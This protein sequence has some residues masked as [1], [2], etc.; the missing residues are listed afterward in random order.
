MK[1]RLLSLAFAAIGA[2]TFAGGPAWAQDWPKQPIK[3]IVGYSAGGTTDL[4]AR[5]LAEP[6]GEELGAT[7]VVDNRPGAGGAIGASA[8]AKAAP[9]GYTLLFAASPEIAIAPAVDQQLNYDPRKD[10]QPIA[11]VCEIP[12]VL[13]VNAQLP[14]NSVAELRKLAQSKPGELNFASFGNGTSNHLVGELF[15]AE[16]GLNIVHVPFKGSAPALSEVIAG[17]VQMTFD[18]EM[19]VKEHVRSG[20]L[21]ALA[22]A[23]RERSK[24]LPDVPTMDEAGVPGFVG[25]SWVGLLAPTGTPADVL[26]KLDESMRKVMGTESVVAALRTRGLSLCGQSS[27]REFTRFIDEDIKKWTEVVKRAGIKRE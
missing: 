25:G 12:Q 16:T 7:V 13:V 4:V 19:V 27:P 3:L 14:V 1:N 21:K 10:L 8:V 22:F 18:T 15:N 24:A 23:G 2:V 17:R 26:K 6:L 20:R 9:D 11:L 5:T